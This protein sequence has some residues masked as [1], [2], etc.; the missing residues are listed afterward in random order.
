M[1]GYRG[2]ESIFDGFRH[3]DLILAFF[4]CTRFEAQINLAF[5]GEQYQMKKYS[6]LQKLEYSM[7]LHKELHR[8]YEAISEMAHIGIERN[9]KMV[10]ENPFTPP[11]YLTMYWPLK[12]AVVDRNRMD[13]GDYM[14]KPT[15]YWFINMEP[16]NN[17]LM[18]P[19]KYVEPRNVERLK[20]AEEKKRQILRSEIH[21]QYASRFIRQ[22][23]LESE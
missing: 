2:E 9:L 17:I 13:N 23:L 5:R 14:K 18:E 10:I 11:H 3:D 4:P 22:F 6:D 21:P 15:Q 8:N 1:G 20:N 12:P 19:I 7:K 16:K